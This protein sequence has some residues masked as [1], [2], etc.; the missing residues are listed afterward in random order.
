MK[1]IILVFPDLPGLTFAVL[2]FQQAKLDSSMA[3]TAVNMIF[4]LSKREQSY[5]GV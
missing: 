3:L 4:D 5:C 1:P 2:D